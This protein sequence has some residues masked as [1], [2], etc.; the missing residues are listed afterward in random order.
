MY[1]TLGDKPLLDK[2]ISIM[3][4][5]TEELFV[6]MMIKSMLFLNQKLKIKKMI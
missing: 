1:L 4:I 2:Y 6:N 3:K 5:N